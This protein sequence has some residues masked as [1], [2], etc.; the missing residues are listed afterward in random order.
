MVTLTR[1]VDGKKMRMRKTLRTR[2][3][4]MGR[5]EARREIRSIRR[6]R[7]TS[8]VPVRSGVERR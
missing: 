1:T 4:E 7:E 2:V 8:V 3:A 6:R 5:E